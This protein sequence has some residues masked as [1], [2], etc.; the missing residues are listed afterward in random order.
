MVLAKKS[1]AFEKEAE[2]VINLT[3]SYP[4]NKLGGYGESG[5]VIYVDHPHGCPSVLVDKQNDTTATFVSNGSIDLKVLHKENN[6]EVTILKSSFDAVEKKE[7]GPL[8]SNIWLSFE[9]KKQI[10]FQSLLNSN[11]QQ[12]CQAKSI[13][14]L[15]R[16]SDRSMWYCNEIN[17]DGHQL[18]TALKVQLVYTKTGPALVRQLFIRNNGTKPFAGKL[19]AYFDL[20]GTQYFVYNKS[21]WYDAGLP[22]SAKEQIASC[23]VP[24]SEMLQIKRVSATSTKEIKFVNSTCDYQSFIG[25]T[26]QL[27][28][29]PQAIMQNGMLKTGAR[30]KL[31]RFSSPVISAV[32]ADVLIPGKKSAVFQQ[33]LSYV[34]DVKLIQE[35]LNISGAKDPTEKSIAQSFSKAAS[36]LIK[37]T[38]AIEKIAKSISV[39]DDAP[40]LNQDFY[41][42]LPNQKVI[43]EYANSVWTTVEELYENCRAHGAKLADGIELGTRDRGQDMWP[44]MKQDPG[45]VRT[46]L[47]H[48]LSF[49]IQVDD[50]NLNSK[51][52]RLRD[53]LHGMFPRQYPSSWSN[54]QQE[55]YNDNRPY[56]DSPIWL[57]DSLNFYIR[58]TG[59]LSILNEVVGTVAL[60]T[61][62]TPEKSGLVGHKNKFK[63]F[64][65]LLEIF[66]C[67]E[68]HANDSQYGMVQI[69]YGDWCDPVD[70]FGTGKIGDN[71]T[72]GIGTGVS[73]RLSCH[74]LVTLIRTLELFDTENVIS[75][76]KNK[77]IGDDVK[78]LKLFAKKLKENIVK[79]A[80]E[81]TA[82]GTMG[83]IDSIHELKKNS[84]KPDLKK[85][86]LGYT[87]GSYI[88]SREFD[89]RQRRVLTT[90][91]W[92]L[93]VLLEKKDYLSPVENVEFKINELLKTIDRLFYDPKLGLRLY[94]IPIPNNAEA[95]SLVGRMG[96]IP[97]GC[98]E[99][100]EYHHAQIMMHVFRSTIQ[101][102]ADSA[103]SQFKPMISATRDESICG[104]FE[105]PTT[106]Y[107]SDPDN[108]HFGKGM[109]FGLSGSVDWIINFFQNVAGI[110]LNLHDSNQPS[111]SVNANLPEILKGELSYKR[112]IHLSVGANKFKKIPFHLEVSNRSSG[113]PTYKINGKVV[114]KLEVNNLAKVSEIKMEIIL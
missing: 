27:S 2:K 8:S 83:F 78:A 12:N 49:M 41:L 29:F 94:T 71:T 28:I 86:E 111:V 52:L 23:S 107:T 22:V 113:K 93:A 50:K 90:M 10:C 79:F 5:D 30:E 7:S 110:Q 80:W 42:N 106:S 63:I 75:F 59:D 62:D 9:S 16:A 19:W 67:Y 11:I 92:G 100:G 6:K 85:G 44:K 70:M 69:L 74:V 77:K 99:N 24:Y 72:R 95:R 14:I 20:K 45:R 18:S 84:K 31:S 3:I 25:N 1:G 73:T 101:G 98:A 82:S 58:E 15:K 57:V 64:E 36:M 40:K 55:V 68:R 105:T 60:T 109:Y 26:S 39:K 65:V 35:Y 56:N 47:L 66:K 76:L 33:S 87:L 114:E 96:M 51:R 103:W 32:E 37:K 91:S 81:E 61:P 43:S 54:R 53:K 34:T 97:A 46:D 88:G 48:A 13:K 108:P 89:G 38:D 4:V 21:V 104:P 102:Q 17:Q 112:T